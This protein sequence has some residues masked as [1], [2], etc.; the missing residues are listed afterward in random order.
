M[1]TQQS[2]A[3][4]VQALIQ[5]QTNLL[6]N[7]ARLMDQLRQAD[8]RLRTLDAAIEG[9]RLGQS[10]AEQVAKEKAVEPTE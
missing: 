3:E 8:D 2:P 4:Q 5:E 9:I 6:A 7:K 10:L 1:Q